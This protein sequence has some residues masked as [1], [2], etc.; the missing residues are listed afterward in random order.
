MKRKFVLIINCF[1]IVTL[2][3]TQ[4]ILEQ[5]IE[6]GLAN[7][8]S[9]QQEVFI[10]EKSV[11]ALQEAKTL[12]L[13]RV[14]LMAD[15]FLAGGGR[16]VD[17]PAGD[18]LNPVYSS[19]NQL[20]NGN[21][22]PVLQNQSILLNPNNFYDV[23]LRTSM[24][25][26]NLEL[27]FNKRVKHAQVSM[28]Q[29]EI[30]LYRRELVKDIKTAYFSYLQAIQ[31]VRIYD[32]TLKTLAESKRVNEALFRNDKVN[33]AA[34]L[35]AQN[36]IVKFQALRESAQQTSNS[37]LTYFNF[38]LNRDNGDSITIDTTY[39]SAAILLT[40]P[41]LISPREELSKLKIAETINQHLIGLS[42]SYLIP[43]LTTFVDLGS[44]GFDWQLDNKTSYYFLGVS[45]QWDIF[46]SGRNRIRI[47]QSLID[48]KINQSQTD[49]V[50]AQLQ[51][52]LTTAINNYN[53]SFANYQ[54]ATS[55]FQTSQVYFSDMLRLYKEGQALFIELLDAQNQVV[56]SELQVNI[57]LYD[58]Y[59]KAAEIERANASFNLNNY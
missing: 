1:L 13:P 25:L 15:Y 41:L 48:S 55:S 32:N 47:Q 12:F 17:F 54:A 50:S 22:F 57:S 59:I 3:N 18:L 24:P 11:L 20:T 33:R 8:Q 56:Q 30:D 4:S 51:V 36:E 40:D 53:S 23:K 27:T 31:A 2:A 39:Q 26:L 35:R 38:L 28:Q 52:Q 10:L 45:L 44:Q 42:K 5:Y 37:A 6:E 21:D 19:L 14:S 29:V 49:Y 9:I 46:S 58:T 34:V 7:N 43:K 16:T